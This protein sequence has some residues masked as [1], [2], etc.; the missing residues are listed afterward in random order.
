MLAAKALRGLDTLDGM[1]YAARLACA[2]YQC[3]RLLLIVALCLSLAA[4][5]AAS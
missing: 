4:G 2:A 1:A 3:Q 5:A